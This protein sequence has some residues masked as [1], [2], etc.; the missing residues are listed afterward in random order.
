MVY[1]KVLATQHKL[2]LSTI[3]KLWLVISL[4]AVHQTMQAMKLIYKSKMELGEKIM[5]C[6]VFI[7]LQITQIVHYLS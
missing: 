3:S 2:W 7:Q 1:R 4:L 5:M 6:S